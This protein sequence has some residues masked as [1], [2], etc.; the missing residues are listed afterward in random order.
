MS[1]SVDPSLFFRGFQDT[2]ELLTAGTF[3]SFFNLLRSHKTEEI[4]VF[5]NFFSL[6]MEASG[7]I[8]RY[9]SV[10]KITD[11]FLDA[12]GP[13]TSDPEHYYKQ[14]R[15]L[16]CCGSGSVGSVCFGP[17]GSGSGSYYH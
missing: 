16:Q 3:T 9:E 12:G 4:K 5:L 15:S 2:N 17:P 7:A 8:S 13:K 1:G 6:L 11:S 14:S 10:Q